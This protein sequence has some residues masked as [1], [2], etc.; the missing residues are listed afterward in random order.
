MTECKFKLKM[1]GKCVGSL[2]DVVRET[3]RRLGH[4]PTRREI[5]ADKSVPSSMTF[6]RAFGSWGKALRAAGLEPQKPHPSEACLRAV[7]AAKKGNRSDNW[8]GG[9]HIDE[10]GYVVVWKPGHPNANRKGYVLEHRLIMSEHL[11]RP[12]ERGENVHHINGNKQDNRLENLEVMRTGEHTRLHHTGRSKKNRKTS[13]CCYPGCGKPA[14]PLYH[15]CKK[16]YQKQ[17]E[18]KRTG[19][20]SH[21]ELIPDEVPE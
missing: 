13:V 7:S 17:W 3:A 14:T 5:D 12:L 6:R 8:K 4:V 10:Q 21:I 18:R 2:L 15:L 16:H 9:R 11:G 19:L 1:A 20:T